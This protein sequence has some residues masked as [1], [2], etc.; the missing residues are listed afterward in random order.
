M[1]APGWSA[2]V[3]GTPAGESREVATVRRVEIPA[4]ESLVEWNYR[5][6]S[7]AVGVYLTAAGLGIALF[8]M[9]YYL[10]PSVRR[11]PPWLR[12]HPIAFLPMAAL[13]PIAYLLLTPLGMF[14]L[15]TSSWET[16]GH[17]RP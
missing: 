10:A 16:R 6:R 15:D 5:P 1:T 7:Y 9:I 3:N 2:T 8:G 17:G 4:G 14:T 12:V 11:L 13:M